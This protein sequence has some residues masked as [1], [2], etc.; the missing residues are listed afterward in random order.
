MDLIE[1]GK[2]LIVGGKG[3]RAG[4]VKGGG[5][6]PYLI[7]E[8]EAAARWPG[9]AWPRPGRGGGRRDGGAAAAGEACGCSVQCSTHEGTHAGRV[10]SPSTGHRFH[11]LRTE[12]LSCSFRMILIAIIKLT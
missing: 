6:R 9:L 7:T 4:E 10:G 3:A 12:R 5:D 11:I 8:D 2:S 1:P